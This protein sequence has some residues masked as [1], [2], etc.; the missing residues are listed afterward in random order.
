MRRSVLVLLLLLAP[1]G[2]GGEPEPTFCDR[3]AASVE[4]SAV[5]VMT[6]EASAISGTVT[7]DSGDGVRTYRDDR[8]SSH[9]DVNRPSFDYLDLELSDMNGYGAVLRLRAPEQEGAFPLDLHDAEL[10]FCETEGAT[11]SSGLEDLSERGCSRGKQ[12]SALR[13]TRVHGTLVVAAKPGVERDDSRDYAY[14]FRIDGAA[15]DGLVIVGLEVMAFTSFAVMD[16]KECG[17][18]K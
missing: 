3:W 7:I 15:D 9:I 11:I 2:C 16:G 4:W 12:A 1:S 5:N 10:G 18:Q 8:A 17:R 6:Y 13:R 14:A